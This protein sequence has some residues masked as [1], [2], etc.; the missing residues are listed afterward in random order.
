MFNRKVYKMIWLC[1]IC[2]NKYYQTEFLWVQTGHE[3]YKEICYEC[4]LTGLYKEKLPEKT[5][6]LTGN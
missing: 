6:I 5:K 3:K 1:D 4:F 2:D